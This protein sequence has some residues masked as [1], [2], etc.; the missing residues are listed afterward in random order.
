MVLEV[1]GGCYY[2]VGGAK[3]ICHDLLDL[4]EDVAAEVYFEVWVELGEVGLVLTERKLVACLELAVL[5]PLF[6]DCVIRQMDQLIGELASL[7]NAAGCAEVAVIVGEAFKFLVDKSEH[8]ETADVELALHV[9]GRPLDV[10][11]DN[12]RSVRVTFALADDLFNLFKTLAHVDAVSSIGVLAGFDDPDV[13][14][15]REGSR[16]RFLFRPVLHQW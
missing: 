8:T 14:V 10:L 12:K 11:L 5:L 6:L 3:R 13:L 4:A 2:F 9:K 15:R 1:S 16:L 7:E